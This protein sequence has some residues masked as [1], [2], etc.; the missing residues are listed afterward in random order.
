M[1]PAIFGISGESLSADERA[2]FRDVR[3]AGFILF[4]R[5]CRTRDQLR[6]L[7]GSLREAARRDEVPILIDQEGGRVARLKPPE[8]PAFPAAWRFAELYARAP[9]SAIEA[10]RVNAQAIAL[11]LAEVGI[12]VNCAPL[13]DVRS[14]LAHDVI[15]DRALGDEP[16]Q[17]AALGRAVLDGLRAGGVCGIVKHM[18]GHGRA[19][20]DSHEE[21]PVVD[22]SVE[23]LAVDL[24]PF[25]ALHDAPAAMTAHLLYPAW[26]RENCATLSPA[27]IGEV[28]RGQIGFEGLLVSDDLTM[29]A[30]KGSLAERAEA[31]IRAGCDLVLQGS[32]K[33]ADNEAVAAAL[34]P[35]GEAALARL[36]RAL[37]W[38]GS[39]SGSGDFQALAD[40][41]EA[42]LA[43]A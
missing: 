4:G 5:N 11:M 22:S 30:L 16:M 9:I 38:P 31:A 32:G 17:V 10:A 41:R 39:G 40:K 7:T 20:A 6:R 3:P 18:P 34:G 26:D 14:E 13:L 15:G 42:L 36:D 35:I 2:F 1:L 33:L 24:A 28:I 43:L 25:R 29:E 12:N 27:V 21:L 37:A 19:R 23:E 8:W